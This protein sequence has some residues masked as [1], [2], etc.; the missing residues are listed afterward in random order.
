MYIFAPAGSLVLPP[1]WS[2]TYKSILEAHKRFSNKVMFYHKRSCDHDHTVLS[3]LIHLYILAYLVIVTHQRLVKVKELVHLWLYMAKSPY[4]VIVR[5]HIVVNDVLHMLPYMVI[6]IF[7]KNNVATNESNKLKRE[8]DFTKIKS[9]T[10]LRLFLTSAT[11]CCC[12]SL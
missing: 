9:K 2:S 11:L 5:C 7:V 10:R 3:E 6:V 4:M 1:S 8:T 12:P